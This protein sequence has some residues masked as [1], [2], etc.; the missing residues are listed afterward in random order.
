MR[1]RWVTWLGGVACVSVFGMLVM[2]ATAVYSVG[3]QPKIY[4]ITSQRDLLDSIE[5]VTTP[6]RLVEVWYRQRNFKEGD[7]GET[8]PFSWCGW[9]NNGQKVLIDRA[10][11]DA[12]GVFRISNLAASGNSVPLLPDAPGGDRCRGGLF[13]EIFPRA[14]DAPG[15]NC[16]PDH[17]PVLHWMNMKHLNAITGGT[18]AAMSQA[19]QISVAVADGPDDDSSISNHT[20]VSYHA[21]DTTTPGYTRW[22][23]VSFKCGPGGTTTCPSAPIYDASTVID[24]DA[25]YPFLLG[26]LQGH[27]DG[28]SSIAA[29]KVPR[30]SPLGPLV[31]VAV[32]V[33]VRLRADIGLNL[34]CDPPKP[35]DFLVP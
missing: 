20:D 14:C 12:S 13:T 22:Q 35:F 34:G 28:G 21:L 7:T 11:A 9:K 29:V 19:D 24:S 15:V 4:R 6:G 5:G 1:R 30:G 8:D 10:W 31:R 26:M 3:A 33:N 18:A 16:S 27:S 25:E 17:A 2:R 23:K 32:D